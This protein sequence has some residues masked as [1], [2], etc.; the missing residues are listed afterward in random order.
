LGL[1]FRVGKQ[2]KNTLGS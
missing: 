1:D 2:L